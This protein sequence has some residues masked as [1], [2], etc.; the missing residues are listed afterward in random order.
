M[1]FGE[2]ISFFR[3]ESKITQEEL[4]EKL[5]VSRQT[6]SRWENDSALPDV[7]TLI[8]L[9]ELFD[10]DMDTLVRKSA[11]DCLKNQKLENEAQ[12]KPQIMLNGESIQE[13]TNI[14]VHEIPAVYDKHMN[15]FTLLISLGVTLILIGLSVMFFVNSFTSFE[16]LPVICL[17]LFIAVAVSLFIIGGLSHDAFKKDHPTVAPYPKNEVTKRNKY[18]AIAI[19]I[20]TSLI[21][22]DVCMIIFC[23]HDENRFP[24]TF[25]SYDAWSSFV[26][27]LFFIFLSASVFTYVYSGLMKAKLEVEKYNNEDSNEKKHITTPQNKV[28]EAVKSVI[29]MIA[30]VVFLVLGFTLGIWHPAWICFPIGGILCGIISIIFEAV[31]KNK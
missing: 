13:E 10:C 22:V 11:E 4:A 31:H 1:G 29:M 16:V 18:F 8:K 7:E 9:C 30:T 14:E 23:L 15:K 25:S 24:S 5:N 12:N 3:K 27:G 6:V 19:A 17:L 21:L 26:M 2:N 20:A 28:V